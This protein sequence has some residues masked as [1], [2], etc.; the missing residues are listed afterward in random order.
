MNISLIGM[1]GSGKTTIGKLLSEKLSSYLFVDTDDEI[2]KREGKSIN[3]IFAEKKESYFR[4]IESKILK[5][6]LLNDNMV[7]S[8]GGGI[9]KSAENLNLLLEKSVVIYLKS[10]AATILDRIKNDIER[11]LLK[12]CDMESKIKLLLKE[13][14]KLYEKSHIIIDIKNKKTN[15]IVDEIIKK[16]NNYGTY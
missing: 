10:D 8:T 11:P 3:D 9:V 5:E 16:I 12:N 1:M 13:R 14:S 6:I 2:V 15:I 4:Q 7:I